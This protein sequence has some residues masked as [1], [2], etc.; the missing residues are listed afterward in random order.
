MQ[1]KHTLLSDPG[2][3]TMTY[4][5]SPEA[6]AAEQEVLEEVIAF[7]TRRYPDRFVYDAVSGTVETRTPGYCHT[8]RLADYASQPLR[9]AVRRRPAPP[10]PC[11]FLYARLSV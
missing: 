4:V 3:L 9:L 6:T 8:F 5:S 7:T 10:V 11:C 1:L 2:A